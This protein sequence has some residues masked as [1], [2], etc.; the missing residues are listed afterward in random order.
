MGMPAALA[1][2]AFDVFASVLAPPRCAACDTPVSRIATFCVA[3]AST[4]E[5]GGGG[6]ASDAAFVYGGAIAQAIVRLKYESRPELA[7]PL[8]DLFWRS[9][10]PRAGSLREVLVVPVP[11]HPS[12][13]AERGYNQSAL[14]ARRVARHL[15]ATFAPLALARTRSTPKQATLDREGRLANVAGAFRAREAHRVCGRAVLLIDDVSTTGATLDACARA[16]RAAGA[17]AVSTAVLAR[18]GLFPA[19]EVSSSG[20]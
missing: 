5:A 3:C 6:G 19:A 17:S 15:G 4:V 2:L 8:G 14:L 9:L 20:P 1:A 7:R 10:V 11:L 13:L 12:R 18:A 16:L